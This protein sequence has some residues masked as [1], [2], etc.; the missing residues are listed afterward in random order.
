MPIYPRMH[1][2]CTLERLCIKSYVLVKICTNVSIKIQNSR[3]FMMLLKV[4]G[5]LLYTFWLSQYAH[6]CS[7]Y[8]L[9]IARNLLELNTGKDPS[10]SNGRLSV[11]LLRNNNAPA[12]LSIHTMVDC[13][14]NWLLDYPAS[15]TH[16]M[17]F[18]AVVNLQH[19]FLQLHCKSLSDG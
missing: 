8:V 13:I 19:Q 11:I 16:A 1:Q 18:M 14:H 6:F 5:S 17:L 4:W 12:I 15:L 10:Q 3:F 2:R 7:E 9:N